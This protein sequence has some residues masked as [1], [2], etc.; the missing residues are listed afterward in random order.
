MEVSGRRPASE[1]DKA[2]EEVCHPCQPCQ[3]SGKQTNSKGFCKECEEY[4]CGLCIKYHQSMKATRDHTILA[5]KE[6][7]KRSEQAKGKQNCEYCKVHEEEKV[8]FF[9]PDHS[10]LGCNVCMVLEHKSCDVAYIPNV[11]KGFRASD[12][13]RKFSTQL[14]EFETDVGSLRHIMT[15]NGEKVEAFASQEIENLKKFRDEINALLDE[16]EVALLDRIKVLKKRDELTLESSK[17]GLESIWEEYQTLQKM[18]DDKQDDSSKLFISY[19]PAHEK[20]LEMQNKL[21]IISYESEQLLNYQ[22]ERGVKLLPL[23]KSPTALGWIALYEGGTDLTGTELYDITHD[24]LFD[25]SLLERE[26]KE[27]EIKHG[28]VCDVCNMGIVGPRYHCITCPNYDLCQNCFDDNTHF[29]H[30]MKQIKYASSG[31]GHLLRGRFVHRGYGCDGCNEIPI[32]GNRHN[33][34]ICMDYDLCDNCMSNSSSIHPKHK[35]VK[36]K[37]S[38]DTK[39]KSKGRVKKLLSAFGT[40][41]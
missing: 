25:L 2:S 20:L 21:Q 31:N 41:K 32:I 3:Y 36:I 17:E 6:D 28:V 30:G 39:P 4:M 34:K 12:T 24:K 5:E 37:G 22:F 18:F 14:S 10:K 38:E 16:K 11:A 9:C 23:L 40:G 7:F 1:F 13:F 33:C 26:L 15:K 35:L 27:H 8:M 19:H 29:E